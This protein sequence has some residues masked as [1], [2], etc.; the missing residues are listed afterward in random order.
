MV[1]AGRLLDSFSAD[2]ANYLAA[3]ITWWIPVN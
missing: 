2:G 1:D 3:K